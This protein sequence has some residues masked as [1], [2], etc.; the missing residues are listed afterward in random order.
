MDFG[1]HGGWHGHYDKLG[2]VSYALGKALAIDPGTH[3]YGSPLHDGWDR[4]TVA[5]NSVVVDESSQAESTGNLHQY[6]ALPAMSLAIADAGPV[7]PAITLKRTVMLNADYWLDVTAADASD[8]SPL[9][10]S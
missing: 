4:T 9:I 5:H 6:V 3:S 2:Y 10:P 1:P 7:Y 8:G